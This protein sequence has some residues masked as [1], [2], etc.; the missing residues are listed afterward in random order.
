MLEESRE[1]QYLDTRI[2]GTLSDRLGQLIERMQES[3]RRLQEL[4]DQH[5]D[6][7]NAHLEDLKRISEDD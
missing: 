2:M 6:N 3:D 5:V 1:G 4:I 7:T